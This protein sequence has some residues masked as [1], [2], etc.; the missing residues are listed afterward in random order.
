MIFFCKVN[1]DGWAAYN[2][3]CA[4]NTFPD[5]NVEWKSHLHNHPQNPHVDPTDPTN[6]SQKAESMNSKLKTNVLRPLH[7]THKNTLGGHLQEF[8]WRQN[9]NKD[10][11]TMLIY[12]KNL[13][14]LFFIFFVMFSLFFYFHFYVFSNSQHKHASRHSQKY[15]FF[16]F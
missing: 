11:R 3:F 8:E 14:F 6:H 2:N 16:F 7:G 15:I 5:I 13:L 1:S 4:K 12:D 9:H 10:D